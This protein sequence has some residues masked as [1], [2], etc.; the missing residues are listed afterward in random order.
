MPHPDYTHRFAVLVA[1]SG[2]VESSPIQVG[3]KGAYVSKASAELRYA[4]ADVNEFGKDFYGLEPDAD[5]C[6]R[7]LTLL[8]EA[9]RDD[10]LAAVR[11]ATEALNSHCDH[12][13]GGTL[14]FYFSGHG[15]PDGD[16]CLIDGPLS[17]NDLA[18][19]W[20]Y[21]A[22]EDP[23]RHIRLALDS[24][25][26]GMTLARMLL[27]PEHWRTFVLRDAWAAALPSE[28]AFELPALGHG[29][30]THYMMNRPPL[31]VF[32]EELEGGREPTEQKLRQVKKAIRET[33]HFLT[34]GKQHAL[35]LINGHAISVMG[36]HQDATLELVGRDWTLDELVAAL[37]ELPKRRQSRM[38]DAYGGD[39]QDISL[40]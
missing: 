37:D 20:S 5:D 13:N 7:E 27:H 39:G 1:C 36:G 10:V 33:P 12:S 32:Q 40:R 16:M 23:R 2:P 30:L 38:K 35:D 31:D 3:P 34:S 4:I 14:D 26:A 29:V 17:P 6:L 28:E 22:A 15:F 9:T 25:F 21:G 24:C 19:A 8:R 11:V 18:D